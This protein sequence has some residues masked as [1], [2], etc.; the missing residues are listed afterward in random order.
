MAAL[1]TLGKVIALTVALMTGGVSLVREWILTF[2]PGAIKA[3][4]LFDACLLTS[5]LT[6]C[7]VAWYIENRNVRRLEQELAKERENLAGCPH[8]L[9]KYEKTAIHDGFYVHNSGDADGISL[10]LQLI[11]SPHYV[12][13]SEMVQHLAKGGS[14]PL[15]LHAHSKEPQPEH[16]VGRSAWDEFAKDLWLAKYREQR[17]ADQCETREARILARAKNLLRRRTKLNKKEPSAGEQ[18][19][20]TALEEMNALVG[21][22]LEDALTIPLQLSY[23]DLSGRRFLSSTTAVFSV[24]MADSGPADIRPGVIRRTP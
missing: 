14:A 10:Q 4:G 20:S 9:L 22:M 13:S 5:F 16:T 8:I 17:Q 3:P 7:G 15:T 23:S 11:E 6:A 2:A 1:R 21:A 18:I 24:V 19:R 12:L